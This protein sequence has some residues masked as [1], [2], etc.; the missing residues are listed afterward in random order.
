MKPSINFGKK[1]FSNKTFFC[2]SQYKSSGIA[3]ENPYESLCT[4]P[5]YGSCGT[6][7]LRF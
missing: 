2:K 7:V 6:E 4:T 1:L 5:S 3:K